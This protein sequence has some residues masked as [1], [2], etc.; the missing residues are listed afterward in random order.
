M[1]KYVR[2]IYYNARV[3]YNNIIFN[4]LIFC[5]LLFSNS[6]FRNTLISYKNKIDIDFKYLIL[7][8]YNEEIE[9]KYNFSPLD[10][11]LELYYSY[12]KKKN[13]ETESVISNSS[14]LS[15]VSDI[16]LI[17]DISDIDDIDDI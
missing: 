7:I 9:K 1:I 14:D 4:F 12:F 11:G 6:Y 13:D 2:S 3:F 8:S 16:S 15:D 17:Y 10:I 5:H